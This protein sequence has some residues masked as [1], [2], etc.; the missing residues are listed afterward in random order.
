[1]SYK[2]LKLSISLICVSPKSRFNILCYKTMIITMLNYINDD[3]WMDIIEIE[4]GKIVN[5]F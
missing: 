1:M 2:Q 3:L 4:Q 5:L